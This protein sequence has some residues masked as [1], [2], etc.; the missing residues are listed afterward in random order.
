MKKI[1]LAICFCFTMCMLNSCGT[2]S[3]D[4]YYRIGYD[5]GSSLFSENTLEE[6]SPEVGGQNSALVE[7]NL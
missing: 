3:N 4:T 5:I 1:V 7:E 6:E 2:L